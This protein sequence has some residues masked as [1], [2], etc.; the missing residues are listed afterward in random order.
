[1]INC[2]THEDDLI[3][4]LYDR[5]CFW[6]NDEEVR[7]LYRKY[8]E[9]CVYGGL[10]EGAE[11]NIMVIVDNDYINWLDVMTDEELNEAFDEPEERTQERV[12]MR[13][14]DLNLVDWRW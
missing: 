7:E 10:F 9:A 11:I 6:T 1:M 12:C 14:A 5:V 2:K 8:Y 3:E 13:Y 4:M